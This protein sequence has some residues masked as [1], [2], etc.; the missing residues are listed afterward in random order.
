MSRGRGIPS[1]AITLVVNG[2]KVL[3]VLCVNLA[4]M[5]SPVL[6]VFGIEMK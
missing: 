3:I 2:M 1:T 4:L 5:M 6:A